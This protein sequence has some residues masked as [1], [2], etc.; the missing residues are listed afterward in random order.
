MEDVN[1]WIAFY[2]ELA[3]LGFPA[4]LFLILALSY[5]DIWMWTKTHRK[6]VEFYDVRVREWQD[7]CAKVES[8]LDTS[9]DL[10]LRATG[11]LESTVTKIPTRG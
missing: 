4:L 1:P 8:K 10:I 6:I 7:R 11:I 2:Q 5:L 3:S 9:Q